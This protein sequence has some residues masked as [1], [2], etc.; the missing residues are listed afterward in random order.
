MGVVDR[1][2]G[3]MGIES[4]EDEEGELETGRPGHEERAYGRRETGMRADEPASRPRRSALVSLPGGRTMRVVVA[5]PRSF[6]EVQPIADQ[7]KERR[8]V[9]INLESVDK[10]T[11]QKFLHF[12]SGTIYALDGTMQRVSTSIFVFA[13]ANVEIALRDGEAGGRPASYGR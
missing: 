2:L 9:V 8:P 13:P 3:F 10:D 6:E 11:G 4:I 5:E 1:I 12:L 7:L